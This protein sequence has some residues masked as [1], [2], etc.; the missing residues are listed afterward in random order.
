MTDRS[1]LAELAAHCSAIGAQIKVFNF[2]STRA[3]LNHPMAF[4]ALSPLLS[5]LTL[6]SRHEKGC[7]RRE[8]GFTLT[9]CRA[10]GRKAVFIFYD[11]YIQHSARNFRQIKIASKK[12]AVASNND[13]GDKKCAER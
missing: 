10:E 3:K 5:L 11:T 2:L 4:L 13:C 7:E 8:E 6:V 1:H 12:M 9:L